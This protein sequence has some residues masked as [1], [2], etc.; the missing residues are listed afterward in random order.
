MVRK[1]GASMPSKFMGHG[2]CDNI[3]RSTSLGS[4][5]DEKESIAKECVSLLRQLK[6]PPDDLRG[7][8]IQVSKLVSCDSSSKISNVTLFKYGKQGV[9][10]KSMK[11]KHANEEPI[12]KT[13]QRTPVADNRDQ[14]N[15][16]LS[17]RKISPRKM[18]GQRS[19]KTK[20]LTLKN[21]V[22]K[23]EI[24]ANSWTT[25]ESQSTELEDPPLPFLP[26][27]P[28]KSPVGKR[29]KIV[30]PVEFDLPPPSQIDPS[31][32]EALPEDVRKSIEESYK[33]KDLNLCFIKNRTSEKRTPENGQT[34]DTVRI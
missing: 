13:I 24:V 27:S 15:K 28:F 33:A 2:V 29:T 32:F 8:G 34:N 22:N 18:R 11:S 7:M 21:F 6:I 25:A 23:T 9:S 4:P 10:T 30:N 17:P 19:P 3:A 20:T 14:A 1:P 16:K 26:D 12:Q 31:V 5:T